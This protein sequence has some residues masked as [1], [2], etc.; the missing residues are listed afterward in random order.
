MLMSDPNFG[1][2]GSFGGSMSGIKNKIRW[3]V[4]V[5]VQQKLRLMVIMKKA[6]IYWDA[7]SKMFLPGTAADTAHVTTIPMAEV[8]SEVI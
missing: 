2:N 6:S 7:V 4:C 3:N 1:D 8:Q 5:P